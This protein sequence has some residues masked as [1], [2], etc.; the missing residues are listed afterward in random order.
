MKLILGG[1][2]SSALL[3]NPFQMASVLITEHTPI[4]RPGN[5]L[6]TFLNL[7]S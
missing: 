5:E 6:L 2:V 4:T 7:L 1:V 3:Q